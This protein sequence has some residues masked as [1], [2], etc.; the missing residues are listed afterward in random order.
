ML[1]P[2]PFFELGKTYQDQEEPHPAAG[3]C[4]SMVERFDGRKWCVD[5]VHT[6]GLGP[7]DTVLELLRIPYV[8]RSS[9]CLQ[10]REYSSSPISGRV[11][12]HVKDLS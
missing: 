9:Q 10:G 6:L 2:R 11:F 7:G 1:T 5:I 8:S 12:P 4:G 3:G